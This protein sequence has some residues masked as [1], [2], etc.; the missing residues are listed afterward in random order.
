MDVM[1]LMGWR[2]LEPLERI[3]IINVQESVK[4]SLGTFILRVEHG[5]INES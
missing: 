5:I 2:E 3:L 1:L 4:E